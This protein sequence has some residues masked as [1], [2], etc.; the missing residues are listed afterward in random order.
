MKVI[1]KNQTHEYKNNEACVAFEYP[2]NDKDING[3]VIEIKG[4][5]PNKGRVVNNKCKELSYII[6]GSGKVVIEQEEVILREGD[7][8][9]IEPG[10][11]YYWDG[12]MT[13]FVSC[14]PTWYVEQ[15]Q[16]VE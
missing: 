7:L 6:N 5:Y 15:H 12:N 1:T 9:L 4:R 3:A 8:I 16:E 14:V 13:M 10:E 2:L 11:R